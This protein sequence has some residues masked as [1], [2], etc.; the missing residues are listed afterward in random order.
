M[1]ENNP[2]LNWLRIARTVIKWSARMLAG[3]L[4]SVALIIIVGEGI[5]GDGGPNFAKEHWTVSCM[6][7]A[8]LIALAGFAILWWR[9]LLGGLLVLGGMAIFFGLNFL[10]SGRLPGGSFL[11]MCYLPGFLA[12]ISWNL[13]RLTTPK[14]SPSPPSPK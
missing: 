5:L 11:W 9:E 8:G 1:S 3:F 4:L 10:D 6:T 12:I 2:R 14:Q 7:I 13:A